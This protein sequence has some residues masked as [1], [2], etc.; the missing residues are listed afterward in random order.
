VTAADVVAAQAMM[1]DHLRTPDSAR[2]SQPGNAKP[3]TIT[4]DDGEAFD[5]PFSKLGDMIDVIVQ[6]GG[7][8]LDSDKPLG[9]ATAAPI[10]A[11]GVAFARP[12][13]VL[14]N[15]TGPLARRADTLPDELTLL[16]QGEHSVCP[17]RPHGFAVL[18]RG[19]PFLAEADPDAPAYGEPGI[20]LVTWTMVG[21]GVEVDHMRPDLPADAAW[22]VVVWDDIRRWRTLNPEERGQ[23]YHTVVDGFPFVPVQVQVLNVGDDLAAT[24]PAGHPFMSQYGPYRHPL[25]VVFALW[26]MLGETVPGVEVDRSDEPAGR[27]AFRAARR[28]GLNRPQAEVTTVVLRAERRPTVNPGSGRPHTSRVEIEGYW[29]WRWIGSEAAGTRMRVRRFVRKH[30]SCNDES[31][32]VRKN[33]IVSELRR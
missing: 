30:W 20:S 27:R 29:A 9:R 16:G 15:M 18:E 22:I 32:P 3:M 5:V 10:V 17:P 33:K 2:N 7:D 19:M 4:L 21:N 28:A 26:Q 25:R 31:L 14:E 1:L 13:R 12:Y 6:R 8:D 11:Y 24:A 23:G